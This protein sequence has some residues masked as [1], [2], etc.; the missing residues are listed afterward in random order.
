MNHRQIE[1]DIRHLEQVIRRISAGDRIPLSYWRNRI[2]SVASNA[3][4]PAQQSRMR[5]INDLLEQLE[6]LV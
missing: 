1:T 3:L 4:L 6:A 5:R 2:N